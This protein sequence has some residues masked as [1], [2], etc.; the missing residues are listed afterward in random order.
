MPI[1]KNYFHLPT[2]AQMTVL[3]CKSDWYKP[4]LSECS[5]PSSEDEPLINLVKKRQAQSKEKTSEKKDA[6]PKRL[7]KKHLT[8]RDSS[9]IKKFTCIKSAQLNPKKDF[10][11]QAAAWMMTRKPQQTGSSK[12]SR[13]RKTRQQSPNC[14]GRP[15]VQKSKKK[16]AWL[17]R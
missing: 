10:H 6:K 5:D 3:F 14:K 13:G 1:Y 15:E 11:L 8:G 7:D 2:A 17:V 4:F 16:S 9:G 12:L